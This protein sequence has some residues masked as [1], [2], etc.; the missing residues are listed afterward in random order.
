MNKLQIQV[1]EY[2]VAPRRSWRMAQNFPDYQRN[3]VHTVLYALVAAG[4][5]RHIRGVTNDAVY[6]TTRHGKALLEMPR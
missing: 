3:E 6:E 5:I 4:L 2:F 1:L